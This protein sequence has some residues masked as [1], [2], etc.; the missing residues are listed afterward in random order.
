MWYHCVQYTKMNLISLSQHG[1][2]LNWLLWACR[3]FSWDTYWSFYLDRNCFPLLAG[4]SQLMTDCQYAIYSQHYQ[5]I[6]LGMG[7]TSC[8]HASTKGWPRDKKST[9]LYQNLTIWCPI[10]IQVLW[11]F[12]WLD[13]W[14][15]RNYVDKKGSRSSRNDPHM[16]PKYFLSLWGNDI[17]V[18]LYWKMLF[19]GDPILSPPAY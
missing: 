2:H 18:L 12:G 7:L 6:K 11:Y 17:Q 9:H 14:F 15:L 4:N 8:E 5:G 3:L 1:F 10:A 16:K 13:K 19:F